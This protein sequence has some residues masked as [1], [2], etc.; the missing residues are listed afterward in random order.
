MTHITIR[1]Q[2]DGKAVDRMETMTDERYGVSR[3]G[4]CSAT[5]SKPRFGTM[6]L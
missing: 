5:E 3:I 6:Q 1:E 4:R 2:L